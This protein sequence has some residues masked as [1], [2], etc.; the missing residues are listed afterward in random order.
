MIDIPILLEKI[1]SKQ[2]VRRIKDKP[3]IIRKSSINKSLSNNPL[4]LGMKKDDPNSNDDI[5]TISEMRDKFHKENKKRDDINLFD[6]LELVKGLNSQNSG[7]VL[8]NR[9]GIK[10]ENKKRETIPIFIN[11]KG[12]KKNPVKKQSAVEA[13]EPFEDDPVLDLR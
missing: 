10:G 11:I 8:I 12:K 5:G 9:N 1:I 4:F 13:P 2:K 7:R 6:I 3:V